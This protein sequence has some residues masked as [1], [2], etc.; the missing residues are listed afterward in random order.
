MTATYSING[1]SVDYS[2]LKKIKIEREDYIEYVKDI[3]N[4][5]K[6]NDCKESKIGWYITDKGI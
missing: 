4:R 5:I 3:K 6:V 2:E 1:N